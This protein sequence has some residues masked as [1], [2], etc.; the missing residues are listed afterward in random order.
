M[1]QAEKSPFLP[2]TSHVLPVS[3]YS[4][5]KNESHK[6]NKKVFEIR[7]K[8]ISTAVNVEISVLYLFSRY[9]RFWNIRENMYIIK[10]NLYYA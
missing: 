9:L 7:R 4:M 5:I 10:N 2:G 3:L 1:F 8:V 6:L